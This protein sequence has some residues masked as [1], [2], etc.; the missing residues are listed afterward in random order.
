MSLPRQSL[1]YLGHIITIEGLR[2]MPEKLAALKNYPRPE[3]LKSIQCFLGMCNYYRKFIK[4]YSEISLPLTRLLSKKVEFQW[5]KECQD[6]FNLLR[7]AISENAVLSFP[8]FEK[9][10]YLH[11]DASN[12]VIGA[13][14]SQYD[15]EN[16]LQ[17]ITFDGKKLNPAQRNYA[18][19]EKEFYAIY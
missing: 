16:N 10:I 6:A 8:Q 3:N 19:I 11:T 14:L 5:T 9:T 12:Y 2:P 15:K 17:P 1:V 18:T 4:N 7:N 13:V